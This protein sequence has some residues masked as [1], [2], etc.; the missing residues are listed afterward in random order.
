[1]SGRNSAS[2]SRGWL[3]STWHV[4]S[5]DCT[6]L[7]WK[8]EIEWDDETVPLACK[9]LNGETGINKQAKETELVIAATQKYTVINGE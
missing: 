5:T 1:M 4:K 8:L 2:G 7:C 3:D 6:A 9:V